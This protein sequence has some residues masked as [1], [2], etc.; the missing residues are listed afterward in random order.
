MKKLLVILFVVLFFSPSHVKAGPIGSGELKLEPFL[1]DY[2]I[3]YIQGEEGNKPD[4]FFILNNGESAWYIF[5]K[6]SQ[7][8]P[9]GDRADIIWCENT[10]KND[11]KIFAKGR[12]I[13]WSNGINKGNKDSRF[14]SKWSDSEMKAKLKELGFL[15]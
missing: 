4:R 14:K 5:C 9:G 13:K 7:C 15:D 12:T 3:K 6:H 8:Q 1:V 11:C 2:F 10:T